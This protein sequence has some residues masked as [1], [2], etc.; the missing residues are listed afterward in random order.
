MRRRVADVKHQPLIDFA[1]GRASAAQVFW[2]GEF[3]SE[4]FRRGAF[5]DVRER[6]GRI[7]V[8]REHTKGQTVGKIV[9]LDPEDE[10]VDGGSRSWRTRT[11]RSSCRW[12]PK[13]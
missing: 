8:N 2:R 9:D 10:G 11:A 3:W 12:P 5:A 4:V 13:T 6:A 7:R 1:P